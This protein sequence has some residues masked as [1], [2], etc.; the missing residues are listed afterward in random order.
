MDV[1]QLREIE[2]YKKTKVL[3]GESGLTNEVRN[4][5]ITDAPDAFPWYRKG[6]FIVTTGYPFT[7][8]KDWQEGLWDF[9]HELVKRDSA[10][11]GIKMGRYIPYLPDY[12]I[13]FA[14]ENRFPI[15]ELP[16]EPSWTDIIVPAITEINKQQKYELEMTHKVYKRFQAH[17]KDGGT[18]ESLAGFL[19][20]FMTW[21]V[22]IYIREFNLLVSTSGNDI[23]QEKIESIIS[24]I[25]SSPEHTAETIYTRKD[26]FT[27][28]WNYDD[29]RLISAVFVWGLNTPLS[30][31]K[32]AALEQTAIIT[33]V[34]TER[35]RTIANTY[36]HF[37]NDF[38]ENLLSNHNLKPEVISRRAKEV[39]WE[40]E[41]CY[42]VVILDTPDEIST[43][44]GVPESQ[45]KLNMLN[46]FSNELR[47]LL[48]KALAGLDSENRLILLVSEDVGERSLVHNLE[49]IAE[50]LKI[51]IIVGGM[52]R[53]SSIESLNDSY[54][55]A[56]LALKVAYTDEN[57]HSE[58]AIQLSL[59]N[60]A[61]LDV[62]RILFS[63]NP[64]FESEKLVKEYLQKIIE[65]DE[66]NNGEILSTLK[67]FINNNANYD[68]TAKAM[69]VHKNTVRYRINKVKAMT[70]LD[71]D[72]MKDLLLLQLAVTAHDLGKTG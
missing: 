21:P 19:E 46:D 17:L 72:K 67:I 48:P 64:R 57:K 18:L 40:V 60:F 9:L 1:N 31:W 54:K 63:E 42:K 38:L 59:C 12:V 5:T 41:D 27:V 58:G 6:D 4:V 53:T 7:S 14:D 13:E 36:Q 32:K 35:L 49:I 29:Q 51:K 68:A 65:Y 22:T 50:R 15:L 34:E 33:S 69:F 43:D 39:N 71:P 11:I 66:K 44:E 10:G 70:T 55:E 37:R 23:S 52:G 3:A 61:R 8:N 28:R 30:A 2:V 24:D 16:S 47:W 20:N 25:H 62:E 26:D 56:D 45:Q